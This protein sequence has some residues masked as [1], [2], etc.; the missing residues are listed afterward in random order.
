MSDDNLDVSPLHLPG[1]LNLEDLLVALRAKEDLEYKLTGVRVNPST[2]ENFFEF[3]TTVDD[4]P[5][6]EGEAGD[7]DRFLK[8][9]AFSCAPTDAAACAAGRQDFQN[10]GGGEI[11][12]DG[13]IRLG[14]ADTYV[15]FYRGADAEFPQPHAPSPPPPPLPYIPPDAQR[16]FDPQQILADLPLREAS[17]LRMSLTGLKDSVISYFQD[18][19]GTVDAFVM[20]TDADIDTDGPGGSLHNDPWYGAETSLQYPD[21]RG[22]CDSRRFPGV[23]RSVR[24]RTQFGL[25]LGDL[26]YLY[27]RGKAVACQIYDQGVDSKIGEVSLYAAYQVGVIP[28][29]MSE[30]EAARHGNNVNDLITLCFPGSCP[31]HLALPAAEIQSRAAACLQALT[32]RLAGKGTAPT[33]PTPVANTSPA[34][35]AGVT[36]SISPRAAWRALPA[37]VASFATHPAQGIVIHN[38]QDPNRAPLASLE[39]EEHAAFA[40]SLRIQHSHMVDRGWWDI[41]QHFTVSRGG[42]IMEART[43]SLANAGKGL[44]VNGAHAGVSEYN[45]SWWGIELEG[46]YRQDPGAITDEQAGALQALCRWLGTFVPRFDPRQHVKGHREVKPGGTD[47]PGKLLDSDLRPDFLTG[48]RQQL[49]AAGTGTLV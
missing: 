17:T 14:S 11:V 41:G 49:G 48:L 31:E 13:A 24:L 18:D 1:S 32:D 16:A 7:P 5:L 6:P 9:R 43:G 4:D 44:V 8:T 27:Y 33:P 3:T 29:T 28:P 36:L 47:C 20:V 21:G 40:L 37:K 42:V 25:K 34:G 30:Y 15:I 39:A 26:A 22:S 10:F 38:T 45:R 2:G 35:R 46:D 23:V 19:K 12:L